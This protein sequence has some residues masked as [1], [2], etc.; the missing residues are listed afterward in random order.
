MEKRKTGG[1]DGWTDRLPATN[2][3]GTAMKRL[4][5][6]YMVS[7]LAQGEPPATDEECNYGTEVQDI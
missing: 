2:N 5:V 7:H 6:V 1:K 3:T 4:N